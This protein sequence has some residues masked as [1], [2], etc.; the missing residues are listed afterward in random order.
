MAQQGRMQS[1]GRLH[2]YEGSGPYVFVSYAHRDSGAVLPIIAR[3]MADGY[4]VW[5][6][7]GIDPGTEWDTDIAEHIEGCAYFIALISENYLVSENCKDE[8]NFVRDL[9]KPRL[10]VY[11]ADVMLP[12]GMRMRL[13]RLQAIHK[14]TYSE[15]QDFYE[16]L[17]AAEGISGCLAPSVPAD[18]KRKAE[19][20]ERQRQAAE[21]AER[22]RKCRE[23]IVG[24]FVI[25]SGVLK[26]YKGAGG[27]VVI[28]D[29]VTRIG[30]SAFKDCTG[31]TGIT[32]PDSVTSIGED[33][34]RG[35]TSLTGI[36]IPDSVTSIGNGVFF[37]CE[38]LTEIKLPSR[39]TRI[40]D[41]LF[42]GCSGLTD[43]TLPTGI[44]SVGHSAFSG[45]EYLTGIT[46]PDSVTIIDE[47]AFE[48]C[49]HLTSITIPHNVTSIGNMA[50]FECLDLTSITIPNSILSIGDSAFE[51][52]SSLKVIRYD[53][54]KQAWL[55]VQKGEDWDLDTSVYKV[56]CT[57]GFC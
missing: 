40:S 36:T 25:A 24:D 6:D 30:D 15:E 38:E 57:D 47:W 21:E 54:T 22:R 4:R 14:Y 29:G 8:L 42:C 23:E 20:A 52:C 45:C 3:M 56:Y 48:G 28:P 32:I 12:A 53:G 16:K 37:Y 11:L 31:L 10:L 50:F 49:D 5:F 51:A 9:G 7:E 46:L 35:C 2:S 17:Y 55:S 13:G 27:A 1:V 33:A 19:E 18:S 26:A 43:I 41:F 39:I 44:T 34:F